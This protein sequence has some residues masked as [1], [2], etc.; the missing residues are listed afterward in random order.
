MDLWWGSV[1][2]RLSTSP[3]TDGG[4]GAGKAGRAVGTGGVSRRWV[5]RKL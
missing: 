2:V 5:E 1:A 4:V 3:M